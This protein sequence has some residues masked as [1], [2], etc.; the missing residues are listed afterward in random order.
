MQTPVNPFKQALAR[1]A[2]AD[3]PVAR[4]GRPLH[5]RDL[6]RR[7]LRLAAARRRALAQRPAH[8]PAAGAG[9]RRL[10]RLA[11]HR[12]CPR[13]PRQ[14]RRRADQAVPRPGRP[15]LARADGGHAG[16]GARAG[17]L[18]CAIRPTASAA[19]AARAPRA[20][21]ACPT[22]RRR[23]TTRSACWCRRSRAK[24]LRIWMPS[25]R[26]KAST[27][28]SSG[29]PTSPP[30]WAMS[31]IPCIPKC[32]PPSRMRSRRITRAGKAAGILTPDETLAR[33]YLDIG[34]VFVAVGLDT[35]LLMKATSRS[36]RAS[37]RWL[38]RKRPAS[39]HEGAPNE[40]HTQARCP[41]HAPG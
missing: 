25:P 29:R 32:R 21:A 18:P 16:A 15:D 6:R 14:R 40:R 35:N 38:R 36:P 8:D 13:G 22:M 41:R 30:P 5:H 12:P 3:R 17:A 10:P 24:P 31:A 7:R 26:R 9:H 33:R 11:R 27:A 19:W 28:S 2:A 39:R 20:G 37:R 4:P 34:A 23:P 1:E